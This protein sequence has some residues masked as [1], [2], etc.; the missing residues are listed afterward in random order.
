M[1]PQHGNALANESINESLSTQRNHDQSKAMMVMIN[2]RA[3]MPTDP[4][5]G[6]HLLKVSKSDP[7]KFNR[8]VL[9]IIDQLLHLVWQLD[10]LEVCLPC[11]RLLT[12][13]PIQ[14]YN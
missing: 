1:S 5:A 6:A 7:L 4:T 9:S 3:S 14:V 13:I 8:V 11:C 12:G 10:Q 2:A